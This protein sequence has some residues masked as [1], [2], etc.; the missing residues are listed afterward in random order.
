[1][2]D[3]FVVDKCDTWVFTLLC[4]MCPLKPCYDIGTLPV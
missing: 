4:E 2:C 1:M 3:P